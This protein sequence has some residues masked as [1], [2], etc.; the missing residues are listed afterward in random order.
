M[1]ITNIISLIQLLTYT[2]GALL[3]A[4]TVYI[5]CMWF[6]YIKKESY[7]RNIEIKNN[8]AKNQYNNTIP[9]AKC[10]RALSIDDF[11]NYMANLLQRVRDLKNKPIVKKALI[12]CI[13]YTLVIRYENDMEQLTKAR[14][15][16]LDLIKLQTEDILKKEQNNQKIIGKVHINNQLLLITDTDIKTAKQQAQFDQNQQNN[17]NKE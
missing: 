2:L 10:I 15:I 7:Y 11:H 9:P 13:D 6:A 12:E 3:I 17:N 16:Y 5:Y 8:F 14:K 1:D 4:F